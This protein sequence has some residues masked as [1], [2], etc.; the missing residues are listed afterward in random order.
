MPQPS[1][2]DPSVRAEEHN[3]LQ[4]AAFIFFTLPRGKADNGQ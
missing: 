1:T 2:P 4:L 3:L